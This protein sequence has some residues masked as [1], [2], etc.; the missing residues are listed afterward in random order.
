MKKNFIKK[1]LLSICVMFGLLFFVDA[2]TAQAQV[3]YYKAFQFSCK[4]K[5]DYGRWSDWTDWH[6]CNPNI[7]ITLNCNT[8]TVYIY[9]NKKQIYHITKYVRNYVDE[10]GG[11]Q[12]EMRFYDQDYDRGTMRLRTETNGNMQI[13]VDFADIMWVYNVRKASY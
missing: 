11:Q 1:A 8:N 13:Y 7:S 5:D 12:A 10:S 6:N 2:A 9:S 4:V 3:Y